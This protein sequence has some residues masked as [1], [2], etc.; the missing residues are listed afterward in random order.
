MNLD[1]W[2]VFCEDIQTARRGIP[3]DWDNSFIWDQ[4]QLSEFGLF[5]LSS[6]YDKRHVG[7]LFQ[8]QNKQTKKYLSGMLLPDFIEHLA[9]K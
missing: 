6:N 8:E 7:F 5:G 3:A 9:L 4:K 2:S 1:W